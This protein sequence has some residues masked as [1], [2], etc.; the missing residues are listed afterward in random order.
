MN[1]MQ[2]VKVEKVTLNI[3]TGKN[4]DRLAKALVLLK[5]ITGEEPVK[6]VTMKRINSWGLRPGL[7]IGAKVTLRKDKAVEVIKKL[8]VAKENVLKERFYDESGNV[9]FGLVEYLDIPGMKYDP[10][11]GTLGLQ[12]CI[13][14]QRPGFRLKY[15]KIQ[16][17]KIPKQHRI[18]KEDAVEFMKSKFGITVGG[19]E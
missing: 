18:T 9:S 4:Q 11:I 5:K 15:R 10:D 1:V 8:L 17:K 6:T 16:K 3:G 14:L 19:E 12:A 2:E 7:P 13:T